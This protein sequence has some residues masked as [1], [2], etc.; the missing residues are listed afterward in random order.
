MS[1]SVWEEVYRQP[2]DIMERYRLDDG[3]LYRNRMVTGSA[4]QNMGDYVWS[5]AT[6]Y[7]ADAAAPLARRRNESNA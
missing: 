6:T 3:Y 1:G 7:V 4:A 2:F 5:V